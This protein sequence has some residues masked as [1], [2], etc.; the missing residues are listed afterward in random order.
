MIL[1]SRGILDTV[2]IQTLSKRVRESLNYRSVFT[3]AE[4]KC[5]ASL[6]QHGLLD[7]VDELVLSDVDLSTVPAEQLTALVSSVTTTTN[8]FDRPGARSNYILFPTASL[9]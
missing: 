6:A 4:L 7:S 9:T 1:E 8:I 5:G 2:L 3:V